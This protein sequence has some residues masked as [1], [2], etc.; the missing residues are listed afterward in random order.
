MPCEKH[1]D[2]LIE[3]AANGAVLPNSLR[4]HLETCTWCGAMLA[5]QLALFTAVDSNMRRSANAELP[6]SF[7]PGVRSRLAEERTSKRNWSPAWAAVAAS[8]ALL[9]GTVMVTRDRH[10]GAVL[11]AKQTGSDS[12]VLP[13][14]KEETF[15]KDLSKVAFARI[16]GKGH[17]SQGSHSHIQTGEPRLSVPGRNK[18]A[19]DQL[20]GAIARGEIDGEVLL[21][22]APL[23]EVGKLQIPRIAIVSIAEIS[24]EDTNSYSSEPPEVRALDTSQTAAGRTK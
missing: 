20:I 9:I 10:A 5:A 12:G 21:T 2:A 18:E 16:R 3:A 23:G 6:D 24:P 15:S 7:L 17:E 13:D 4:E 11:D 19:I 8:V 14:P 1:K 22:D